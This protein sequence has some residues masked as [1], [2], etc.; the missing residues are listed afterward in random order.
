MS[1]VPGSAWTPLPKQGGWRLFLRTV[2]GRAYPRVIGSARELSWTFFEVLLPILTVLGYVWVYRAL[3]APAEYVGFVV[4]GGAMI[5]FWSNVLWAMS[6]Q[7]YWEKEQ[8]NLALYI[9]APTSLMAVLLGMAVGGLVS[10]AARAIVIVALGALFFHV[11]FEVQS[12]PMLA[13]VF[14]MTLVALYGLGMMLASLFLL[15]NREA[16][17]LALLIQEPV[18]LASGFFFPITSFPFWVTSVSSIVPLTLGLDAIRQ[19][20]FR[21]GSFVP[22]LGA[23]AE[24]AILTLLAVLY[25]AV[26]RFLLDHMERLAVRDGRITESRR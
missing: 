11:P 16:W 20:V 13:A 23:R 8:G 26:A 19:L 21:S 14:L 22:F 5:A 4:L 6:S 1:S 7:L 10:T 24:L 25:V 9:M 18:Y 12:A 2:N 17:H 15:L 3:R